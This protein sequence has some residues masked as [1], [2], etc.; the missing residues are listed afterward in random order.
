[1]NAAIVMAATQ[2][3]GLAHQALGGTMGHFVWPWQGVP[4]ARGC[5]SRIAW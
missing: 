3:A 4:I 5:S 1:M 2:A